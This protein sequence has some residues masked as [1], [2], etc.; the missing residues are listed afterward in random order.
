MSRWSR[1]DR[2]RGTGLGPVDFRDEQ[3]A[4]LRIDR[5]EYEELLRDARARLLHRT[6]AEYCAW[7]EQLL[8]Q[9]IDRGWPLHVVDG[10]AQGVFAF[11]DFSKGVE[12]NP[13][14]LCAYAVKLLRSQEREKQI[15]RHQG[16]L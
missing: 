11:I 2:A 15:V 16:S 10:T 4:V 5:A 3:I 12:L 9:G 8:Q 6:W 13:G 7:T 1:K 14:A